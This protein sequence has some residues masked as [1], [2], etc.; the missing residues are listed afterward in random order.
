MTGRAAET[1]S[2]FARFA[3]RVGRGLRILLVSATM[4]AP[5]ASSQAQTTASEGDP[6]TRIQLLLELLAD[7]AV[8]LAYLGVA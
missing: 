6:P 7:P 4:F 1:P 8:K 2:G 3:R 5:T